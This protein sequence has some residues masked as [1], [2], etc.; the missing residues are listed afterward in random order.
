MDVETDLSHATEMLIVDL[1]TKLIFGQAD[2][3]SEQ[4]LSIV[5]ALR[6]V[7]DNILMEN[8][9][10]MGIYLRALGVKEMIGLVSRVKQGMNNGELMMPPLHTGPDFLKHR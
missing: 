2:E 5:Q 6:V 8:Y 9:Q 7:D 4:E 3:L 10:E 1:F